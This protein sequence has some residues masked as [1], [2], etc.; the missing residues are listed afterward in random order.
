MLRTHLN[1]MYKSIQYL[2]QKVHDDIGKKGKF[3]IQWP[4][5]AKSIINSYLSGKTFDNYLPT[6]EE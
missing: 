4:E 1:D 2:R 5:S 3:G 6:E